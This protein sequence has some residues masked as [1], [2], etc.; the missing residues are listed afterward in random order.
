MLAETGTTSARIVEL[1]AHG[2]GPL[3]PFS[4]SESTVRE[5]TRPSK[6]AP[7]PADPRVES[8]RERVLARY[9]AELDRFESERK[10]TDPLSDGDIEHLR[11]LYVSTEAVARRGRSSRGSE[12]RDETEP[13]TES[14]YDERS[15]TLRRLAKTALGKTPIIDEKQRDTAPPQSDRQDGD[16]AL[17]KRKESTQGRTSGLAAV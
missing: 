6:R 16:K 11:R 4:I 9:E 3:P 7:A 14:T 15:P 12:S 2:I 10:P 17:A 5:M 8:I 13:G 1:A